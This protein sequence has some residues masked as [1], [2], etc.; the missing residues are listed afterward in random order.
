MEF[1]LADLNKLTKVYNLTYNF[2]LALLKQNENHNIFFKEQLKFIIINDKYALTR[3]Y[4]Y[5]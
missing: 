4:N 2:Y 3:D 1:V 5:N